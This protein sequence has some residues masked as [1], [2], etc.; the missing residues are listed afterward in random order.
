MISEADRQMAKQS[1][2]EAHEQGASKLKACEIVGVSLR[3]LQRWEHVGLDDGRKHRIQTPV[4]KLSDEERQAVIDCCN[5]KEHQSLSPKQ[6]VPRLADEGEYIASESSFYR[7]LKDAKQANA[8]GRAAKPTKKHRPDEYVACGPN[9]VFSWDITYLKSSVRGLFFYLYLFIDI[10]SR[11]IVGWEVM[12]EESA[13]SA[14][15]LLRKIYL[16]EGLSSKQVVLHSDNGSPMKGATMLATM[17]KLGVIPSFS[18]PSVS[19]DNAYSESL[20]KT[21]KYVPAYPDKPFESLEDARTWVSNFVKWY[22][23]EH[24]HSEIKYV[25]PEQRHQ[26]KDVEIL[27]H[28]KLVYEAAKK[29]N[30]ERWSGETR[31]WSHIK[32]VVLN[33]QNHLDK[34]VKKAA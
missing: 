27:A 29:R 9:E 26:G 28:R 4:N 30:P 25:T 16:K 18:R 2:K 8:R 20:F 11:E 17:Q 32:T 3:T 19:N 1:M 7:I 14:A 23:R 34:E 21:M 12:D 33:R 6:I 5:K 24:R 13:E 22:N 15:D 31:D 10:F